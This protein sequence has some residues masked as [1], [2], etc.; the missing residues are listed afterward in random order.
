MYGRS[1]TTVIKML[2]YSE[3]PGY[4]QINKSKISLLEPFKLKIEQPQE[5]DIG[6]TH[7]LPVVVGVLETEQN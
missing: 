7:Q 2:S 5:E 1:R 3:S 6:H 4:R